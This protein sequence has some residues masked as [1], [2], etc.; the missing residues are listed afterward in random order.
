MKIITIT[1]KTN[2]MKKI[3]YNSK[4]KI[5]LK[6]LEKNNIP[7][8]YNC[9]NGFCGS[10]KIQLI[11]GKILYCKKKKPIAY[12]NFKEI[13]PCSCFVIENIIIKI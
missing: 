2:N 3:I 7:I 13:L 8:Q 6:I 10:C 5:L 1:I 12:C 9:R 4:K 11:S